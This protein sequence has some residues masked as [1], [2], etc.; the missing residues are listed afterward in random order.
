MAAQHKEQTK[1]K[2]AVWRAA[3]VSI[4]NTPILTFADI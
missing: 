1:Q 4:I 2:L 3:V